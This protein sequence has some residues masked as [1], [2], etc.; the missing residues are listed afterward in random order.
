ME[1]NIENFHLKSTSFF[2]FLSK[3]EFS[4]IQ[5]KI[6]RR[7]FS[8]GELLFKEKSYSKGVYIIRKGKVKFS[9]RIVMANRV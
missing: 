1:F 8:K 2:D 7:E 6:T 5:S 9:K 3:D 4:S